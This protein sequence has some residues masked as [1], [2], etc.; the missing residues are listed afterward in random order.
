MEDRGIES[1]KQRGES[2]FETSAWQGTEDSITVDMS[3]TEHA[4]RPRKRARPQQRQRVSRACDQCRVGKLKCDGAHPRCCTCTDTGKPC[5]YDGTSRRRGLKTGYVRALECLWGLVFQNVAESEVVVQE[6]LDAKLGQVLSGDG[7]S[8]EYWRSSQIPQKIEKLLSGTEA[9]EEDIE[10]TGKATELVE[11]RCSGLRW[12]TQSQTL[13]TQ[14]AETN[15]PSP[16]GS[17]RQ[18][19]PMPG[20]TL[21]S[22][23]SLTSEA[24][25]T[26]PKLQLPSGW[27]KLLASFFSYTH[28]WLP[29]VERDAIY[30]TSYAYPQP[31]DSLSPHSLGSGDH[32]LLWAILAYT[33]TRESTNRSE[34]H[35]ARD[36]AKQGLTSNFMYAI[37]RNL[38]PSENEARYSIGHVQA[39]LL[40]GLCH[41]TTGDWNTSW[42]LV[43]QAILVAT[44]LGL[45]QLAV[46][47][48]WEKQL[49]QRVWLGCFVLH[50]LL[51]A[52]LTRVPHLRKDDA[53]H[54]LPIEESGI[55]EWG[56][57][58]APSSNN[59]LSDQESP[60]HAFSTFNQLLKLV[61]ILNDSLRNLFSETLQGSIM[62]LRKWSTE[63]PVHCQQGIDSSEASSSGSPTTPNVLNLYVVHATV[64]LAL[65]RACE[66]EIESFSFIQQE[67]QQYTNIIAILNQSCNAAEIV[68]LLPV[69]DFLAFVLST[70]DQ[71]QLLSK[72]ISTEQVSRALMSSGFACTGNGSVPPNN[73]RG[74]CPSQ[75]YSNQHI[76]P[77]DS[78]LNLT[79]A[80]E[81]ENVNIPY[82]LPDDQTISDMFNIPLKNFALRQHSGSSVDNLF[83]LNAAQ[84]VITPLSELVHRSS[85]SS[86]PRH[87]T[88]STEMMDV[89]SFST[90]DMSVGASSSNDEHLASW[91][92]MP[93]P[94][95]ED[96]SLAEYFQLLDDYEIDQATFKENLGYTS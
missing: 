53:Q 23:H 45:N 18:S 69:Y 17:S 63:L 65:S 11:E 35:R 44:E 36:G 75:N 43:G 92:I 90:L 49:A 64:L 48:K 85:I 15:K 89:E 27:R 80:Q 29:I 68:S 51:S 47:V 22:L 30:R 83:G 66:G 70:P 96:N 57:W 61:I 24:P 50:T 41:C 93:A 12:T 67:T 37:A 34:D 94:L 72:Q 14:L 10:D 16:T 91:A 39:L 38:V 28:C 95:P 4:I 9:S 82:R 8:L 46:Q 77:P 2:N 62:E 76:P 7:S 71:P 74:S 55:E 56:P 58:Q 78:G 59:Q 19:Q 1:R 54:H 86:A 33:A 73:I 6:L 26:P 88:P 60:T 25:P 3:D 81:H 5:S 87:Q 13:Q 31:Q 79:R 42:L 21:D 84:D 40:L 20:R 52:W 32:A